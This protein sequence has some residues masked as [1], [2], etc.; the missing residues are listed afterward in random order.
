MPNK[1]IGQLPPLPAPAG[2]NEFAVWNGNATFR[3]SL[4]VIKE[5]A[6]SGITD[7]DIY[8]TGG[9]YDNAT[10][11]ITLFRNDGV[12]IPITGISTGDIYL[13]GGTY[14]NSLVTLTDNSGNIV[15]FNIDVTTNKWHIPSGTT[16][17]VKGGFQSF[18]YGD[19]YVEGLLNLE[20]EG[21]LVV[22]NGD[23]I[24]NGGLISGDGSTLLVELPKFDTKTVSGSFDPNTGVA[25]FLNN[26]GGTFS[27][28]GFNGFDVYVTG[29]TYNNGDYI[30]TNITGGTFTVK[31]TTTYSAGVISGST[32]WSSTGTGQ[33]NL[34][35]LKVALFDNPNNFEP[36]RIYD[37]SA[38]VSDSGGINSLV[39]NDTNYIVINYNGGSPIYQVLNNDGTVNDSSIILYLIVY[40]LGNF[41]HVLEFGNY[42]AGLPNKLNDRIIMTQ[43]FARESGLILGLSGT[44]GVALINGGVAWNGP[45]RQQLVAVNS[46]DDIFFKNYH[47]GG[48]WAYTTTGDT[49]NNSFYDDG[50]DLVSA[51]TGNYLVNYYYRGQE[52][53]DHIYEVYGND[54]YASVL[55][56]EAASEPTLPELI[57][58]HAFLVGRIIVKVGELTGITQTAFGTV[59]QPSGY[60]SGFHNDL[61]N[62]Q[63]GAPGEYYHLSSN[64]YNSLPLFVTGTT[65]SNSILY[66]DRPNSLSAYTVDLSALDFTGNTSAS[67]IGDIWVSNLHGCSPITVHDSIQHNTSIASGLL[68]TAF[69]GLNVSSG[70]YSHA[71]GNSTTASNNS[72]HAEGQQTTASGLYSHAEG[73]LTTAQGDSS[74]AEG[75]FTTAIGLTSHAEGYGTQS[76]GAESHAEGAATTAIGSQ[77]HAEGFFTRASGQFSHTEGYYTTAIGSAS[78][79]EGWS[80]RAM[81]GSSHA[82][83]YETLAMGGSSHAEGI[84]TRASGEGSHAEGSGTTAS[85]IASHAEGN[86][87][88]AS[89]LYSH[90]EGSS[91]T[92]QGNF[93][94]AGGISSL[95]SGINSFIHSSGSTVTG[96]RSAVIGGKGLSG[97]ANDTVYVPNFDSRGIS[98]F[99][100]SS[101]DVVTIIGSGSASPLFKV[102]GSSGEL[103]TVSDSLIGS[104][105]SVND[106]SGLPV[107]EA[108][109]D[110]TILMGSY[111]APSLNTTVKKSL[112]SGTN[113]IYSIPTSAYT[114]A[115]FDY[116][117]IRSSGARA[118]NIMSIWSGSSVEYSD[119]STND[120][121]STTG[122]T[123]S[124]VISGSSA[125]LQGTASTSGWTLKTIVRSI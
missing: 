16:L 11:T 45:N 10:S 37:V 13:T 123:F 90:A 57:T 75:E 101:T 59:F 18:I 35:A 38:G 88:I 109:S 4:D 68:S 36:I 95:A 72:A 9:T 89:G 24:L 23:I 78:H 8:V 69:G 94:H 83:G 34:P 46:Q 122:V 5:Y 105:F 102:Q 73:N 27:V 53:N 71:E 3:I 12:T 112:A 43:R 106:I 113:N 51:T 79:A 110:N 98:R 70:I 40:R 55:D 121:G 66:F 39:D 115:F 56:A 108:F 74:H 21:Q 99:S 85:N 6:I 125:V 48:V 111:Q 2:T 32:G 114:G 17:T 31:S 116:T 29:G 52:I 7:N 65:L 103:F 117:L 1:T 87:T 60:A 82:E 61:L 15:Q 50:T 26:S 33:I 47:V 100:G 19:L 54:E 92:A 25:T 22:L 104:L 30:F 97:P 62:I 63:G 93:S 86:L 64:E 77:S 96:L 91:T 124:V 119:V 44:T 20:D 28:S 41:I 120:I 80:T 118:G 58:S 67:C 84:Q 49:I 107:L 14:D 81:G 42:G 76:I